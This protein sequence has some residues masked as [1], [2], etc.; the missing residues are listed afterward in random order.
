MNNNTLSIQKEISE[1]ISLH[2]KGLFKEALKKTDALANANPNNAL[3]FNLGKNG[4]D[5]KEEYRRLINYP[6]KPDILIFQY[7]LNDIE[8]AS[9]ENGHS[10]KGFSTYKDL[11]YSFE[12][13]IRSPPPSARNPSSDSSSPTTS[14]AS[15]VEPEIV[16]LFELTIYIP[17]PD[18][19]EWLKID[20]FFIRILKPIAEIQ[21]LKSIVEILLLLLLKPIKMGMQLLKPIIEIS[22]NM[23]TYSWNTI[24]KPY[25]RNMFFKISNRNTIC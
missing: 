4:A 23:K 24:I 16:I 9:K 1:I 17:P 6:V 21:L 10:F 8:S 3:I 18:I 11:S 14:F 7:Y 19:E 5:T 22:P 20:E 15:I 2:E 25:S 13:L 12:F